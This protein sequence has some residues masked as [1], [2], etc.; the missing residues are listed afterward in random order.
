MEF[1]GETLSRQ[2]MESGDYRIR[3]IWPVEP[4]TFIALPSSDPHI[5]LDEYLNH[6]CDATPVT[7]TPG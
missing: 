4:D 2:E 6:S 3:S 5:S 7:R 1:G